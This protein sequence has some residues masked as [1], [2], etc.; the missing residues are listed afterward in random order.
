MAG[1]LTT[2]G[3]QMMAASRRTFFRHCTLAGAAVVLGGRIFAEPKGLDEAATRKLDAIL[4]DKSL[5]GK[6]FGKVL[7]SLP[8]WVAGGVGQVL[9]FPDHVVSAAAFKTDA[10]AEATRTKL[11]E[12]K[13]PKRYAA[14]APAVAAHQV[15]DPTTPALKPQLLKAFADDRT[16]RLS[17]RDGEQKLL[18]TGLTIATVQKQHG[19]AEKVRTIAVSSERDSRPLILTAHEYASGTVVFV[20]SDGNPTAGVVDRVVLTAAPA[21]AALFEEKP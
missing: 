11:A 3:D 2:K 20:E 10:E 19:K 18:A 16:V 21:V 4:A 15:G 5:W 7:T 8:V 1:M 6:G 17:W 13:L 14:R 9:I 12:L